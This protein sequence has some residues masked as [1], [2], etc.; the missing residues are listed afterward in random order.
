MACEK[1]WRGA[2]RTASRV[3]L[4]DGDTVGEIYRR[5]LTESTEHPCT[6]DEQAGIHLSLS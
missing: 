4:L 5:L 2:N 6:P 3:G 1:C